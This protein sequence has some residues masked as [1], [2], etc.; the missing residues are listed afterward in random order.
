MT[1]LPATGLDPGKLHKPAVD[2]W[3]TYNGDYSGKRFSTL[4]KINASNVADLG[5]AWVGYLEAR[6]PKT[7]KVQWR[8]N[9][10]PK[11]CE[12]LPLGYAKF[13]NLIHMIGIPF[14]RVRP[15]MG[16]HANPASGGATNWPP[17]SFDPQTGLFYV[18]AVESHSIFYLT[19]TDDRPEGYRGRDSGVWSQSSLKAIDYSTGK[20][21]W[22]HTFPNAGGSVAGLLTTAGK[23]LFSGD[24]SNNLIAL[25][26][27][28][29]KILWHAGFAAQTSNAR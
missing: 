16:S 11:A 25:D 4:S 21:R 12:P 2:T 13:Q 3:P 15:S 1:L 6:D 28:S 24:T 17:P 27:Q 19:D 10:E 20:V 18:S 8:W 26:P 14:K 29:G 23:L 7:G 5:L 22:S 9:S